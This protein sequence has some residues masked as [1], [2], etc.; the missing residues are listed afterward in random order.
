LD[1]KE[2]EDRIEGRGA[3]KR[4]Q[5][6]YNDGLTDEQFA[7]ALEEEE[8]LEETIERNRERN[9]R[10]IANKL[11]RDRGDTPDRKRLKN[12]GREDSDSIGGNAKR[13][14][15]MKEGSVTPSMNEDDEDIRDNKRRKVKPPAPDAAT[16][17][18]MKKIFSQVHAAVASC[19]DETGRKRCEL[20]KDLPD[21][22]DY[23]D[24]YVAIKHPIS[25]NQIRKRISSTHYR[26]I[27]QFR[28]DWQLMFGNARTYNQEGSWV[29]VDAEE[30]GKVFTERLDHLIASSGLFS[31]KGSMLDD[32]GF[33]EPSKPSKS[34]SVRLNVRQIISDDDDDYSDNTD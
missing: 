29:Y 4:Q 32:D 27:A 7:M 31:G 19:T 17:Q 10:R 34:A 20:F 22:K 6:N 9:A 30:M 3:R 13:K 15:G 25:M 1:V 14:R 24:Y 16:M 8:D 18:K 11:N 33:N 23:P 21:K 12:K 5:V 2:D 26:S 28:D